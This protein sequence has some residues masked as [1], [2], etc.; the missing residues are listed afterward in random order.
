MGCPFDEGAGVRTRILCHIGDNK[1]AWIAC[2]SSHF[3]SFCL[4]LQ[5]PHSATNLPEVPSELIG[6]AL[7]LSGANFLSSLLSY[8][9][10]PAVGGTYCPTVF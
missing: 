4:Q 5:T 8:A 3:P 9:V 6:G 1:Q 10:Q 2:H 7:R